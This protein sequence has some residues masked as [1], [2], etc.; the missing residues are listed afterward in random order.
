MSSVLVVDN[1]SNSSGNTIIQNGVFSGFRPGSII[2]CLTGQCDGSTVTG[3]SGSYVWPNITAVQ[4]ITT[5][6]ADAGGSVI[7]YVPP[8]GA[9]KVIYEYSAF[10]GW[11]HD[12]AI[13]HWRLYIDNVEV[14]FARRNRSGRY[15]EDTSTLR[16]VFNIGAGNTNTGAQSSWTAVKQIKWQVRDYGASNARQ[17]L[18]QTVY[19]DGVG[20]AQF[21]MP[22]LTIMAIA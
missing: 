1:I 7:S 12:H 3:I 21:C 10:L 14:V 22:N 17:L 13:S 19:W 8:V 2:E 5:S 11:A 20:G 15:P 9:K 18:H 4:S 6:Y 16:W